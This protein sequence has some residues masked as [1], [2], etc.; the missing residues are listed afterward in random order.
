MTANE[1]PVRHPR[2]LVRLIVW[3]VVA[4]FLVFLFGPLYLTAFLQFFVSLLAGWLPAALRL[5]MALSISLRTILLFGFGAS[6]LLLLMHHLAEWVASERANLLGRPV[7]W[8]WRRSC[9]LISGA[10][11]GVFAAMAIVASVHQVA[12][13]TSTDDDWLTDISARGMRETLLSM[14]ARNAAIEADFD[15]EGTIDTLERYRSRNILSNSDRYR[16]SLIPGKDG[17][18][19]GIIVMSHP[20]G[21]KT[22][23]ERPLII[24]CSKGQSKGSNPE[25]LKM[26]V[27]RLSESTSA[28]QEA[29]PVGRQ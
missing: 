28:A 20:A 29:Q 2:R 9:L 13:A 11:L 12:W 14:N 25:S 1:T 10:I 22:H 18:V 27:S 17:K 16:L 23:R 6:V 7:A 24:D 19:A 5:V 21:P 8:P 26:E 3:S 15:L 4:L